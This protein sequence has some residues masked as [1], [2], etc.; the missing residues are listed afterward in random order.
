M[1]PA[2]T[3][4]DLP[5]RVLLA[6]DHAPLRR[7]LRSDLEAA[8]F[9]VC[10]EAADAGG[11]VAAALR[12]RPEL[13]LLD[14]RMPGGGVAAAWEITAGLPE[15]KVVMLTVSRDDDHLFGALRAGASGYLLKDADP[16]R[17]AETL[18]AVVA[19]DLVLAPALAAR[20]LE[21]VRQPLP[22]RSLW[23]WPRRNEDGVGERESQ[24]LELM[25][26]ELSTAEIARR[27]GLSEEEVRSDAAA[28]LRRVRFPGRESATRPGGPR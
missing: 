26:R 14:V 18:R 3:P 8:G 23:R 16:P 13:C 28:I 12:E 6:D 9:A 19:G 24:V 21:E 2:A 1:E 4:V 15:T 10:A 11:A 27:L 17:L 7:A 25:R 20:L 5:I 22:R